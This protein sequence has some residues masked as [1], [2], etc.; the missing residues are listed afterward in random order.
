MISP[1]YNLRAT[2]ILENFI[3]LVLAGD[4]AIIIGMVFSNLNN[5]FIS[6]LKP[7][8]DF[9]IKRLLKLGI[10]FLGIRLSFIDLVQ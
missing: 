6:R 2:A 1:C 10:I 3:D 5:W 9:C 8:Y 4:N 7:G